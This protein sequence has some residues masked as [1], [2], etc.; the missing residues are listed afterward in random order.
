MNSKWIKNWKQVI[1][2]NKNHFIITYSSGQSQSSHSNLK[3][4]E[5]NSILQL[6]KMSLLSNRTMQSPI[7]CLK[8][9]FSIALQL[10]CVNNS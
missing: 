1:L 8:K 4:C 10:D 6:Q 9:F 2:L 7:K 5:S 3:G